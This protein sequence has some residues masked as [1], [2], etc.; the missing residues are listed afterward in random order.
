M[1]HW[2][3]K[4][5]PYLDDLWNAIRARDAW[6]AF[7]LILTMIVY[8]AVASGLVIIA[9]CG[10]VSYDSAGRPAYNTV[11]TQERSSI[12][13]TDIVKPDDFE[14]APAPK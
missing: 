1:T 10:Q 9:G 5:I 2:V 6:M 13:R 11:H 4:L 7:K 8:A 3:L 14:V 12:S